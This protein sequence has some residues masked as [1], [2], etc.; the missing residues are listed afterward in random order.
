M[1][2]INQLREILEHS[3]Q[4]VLQE[5][6]QGLSESDSFCQH[7]TT[8]QDVG[9]QCRG[10]LAV[11]REALG[12][13]SA[14]EASSEI[15]QPVREQLAQMC[16]AWVE[17]GFKPSDLAGF[18]MLSKA[19]FLRR[20]VAMDN[21]SADELA[22]RAVGVTRLFDR[23]GLWT[24][25]YFQRKQ[26][27]VID[28]QQTE[29]M[30]LSTPVISIWD[31]VLALP[32]I[33]TLDSSRTQVVV[34]SLLEKIVEERADIAIID[35]TGVPTV[36]T[37]VAQHLLKA[38]TAARLMGAECIIS[39][40]RPSIAQTMVQLG[41]DLREVTTKSNLAAAFEVALKFRGLRMERVAD[42][43]QF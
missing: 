32:L 14:A 16:N 18:V 22:E 43:K 33:G 10:F 6:M 42:R 26:Q 24:A 3:E 35:I 41:V 30:E 25:E 17:L 13:G 40:I 11:L 39:G 15:W 9:E 7:L 20:V 34:E 23:F 4:D 1:R 21:G 12:D 5:W 37:M 31:G 27:S 29:L 28:R 2:H 8:E 38:V 19:P 36:D